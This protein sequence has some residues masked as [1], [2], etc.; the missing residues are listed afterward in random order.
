MRLTSY[1]YGFLLMAILICGLFLRL[2]PSNI[3]KNVDEAIPLHVI[4]EM[5]SRGDLNTDWKL[6]SPPL[7]SESIKYRFNFSSYLMTGY[8]FTSKTNGPV[9][10]F[11]RGRSL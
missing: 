3:Q 9:R 2:P 11:G 7:S 1:Q 4:A 8:L 5:I 6:A 10:S